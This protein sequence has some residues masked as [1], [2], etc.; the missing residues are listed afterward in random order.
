VELSRF[1]D[2]SEED[3]VPEIVKQIVLPAAR[4]QIEKCWSPF[5]R[6]AVLVEMIKEPTG[7]CLERGGED[8]ESWW[9]KQK[10]VEAVWR[11]GVSAFPRRA[12]KASETVRD[13]F[14]HVQEVALLFSLLWGLEMC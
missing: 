1:G 8:E 6:S 12:M 11:S 10:L 3:L 7:I 5:E 2:E 13:N 4:R 14:L 9:I